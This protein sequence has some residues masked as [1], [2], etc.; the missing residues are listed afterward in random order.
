MF[1]L[2]GHNRVPVNELAAGDIGATIKLRST[3]KQ[4]APWKRQPYRVGADRIPKPNLTIA[5]RT[6]NKGDEEKLAQ[7]LH[8]LKEEDATVHFEV[9]PEQTDPVALPGRAAPAGHPVEDR[10]HTQTGCTVWKTKIPYRETIRSLPNPATVAK[11]KWWSRAV[12]RSI[13][14]YWALYEGMPAPHGLSVRGHEEIDLDWGGKLVFLNCIVGGAILMPGG[15]F[16][17]SSKAWWRK[18]RTAH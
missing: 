14:T 16:L 13:H 17:R 7:A 6:A 8:T 12:C 5:I 11:T 1:L 9:S 2:E 3:C 4:H 15:F 18:C 10:T